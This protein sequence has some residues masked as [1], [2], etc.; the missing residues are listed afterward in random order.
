MLLYLAERKINL[1]M[2]P[3]VLKGRDLQCTFH[4][5]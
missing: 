3:E 2:Q 5:D 4:V 1:A